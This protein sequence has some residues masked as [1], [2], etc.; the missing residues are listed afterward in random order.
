[1]KA[2]IYKDVGQGWQLLVIPDPRLGLSLTLLSGLTREEL[3]ERARAELDRAAGPALVQ[4][5][6]PF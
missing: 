5:E 1:M 3:K 6:I 4:E 2:M